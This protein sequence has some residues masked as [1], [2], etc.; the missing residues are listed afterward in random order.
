MREKNNK[1][2]CNF[3]KKEAYLGITLHRPFAMGMGGLLKQVPGT[4]TTAN[5]S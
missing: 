3:P 1:Q 2:T 4:F 5:A